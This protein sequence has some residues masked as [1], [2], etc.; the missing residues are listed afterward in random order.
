MRID[1]L[2]EFSPIAICIEEFFEVKR[3]QDHIFLEAYGN[4]AYALVVDAQKASAQDD[5]KA[6]V[7]VKEGDNGSRMMQLFQRF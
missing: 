2:D 1:P 3:P 4:A 5:V 6:P 7:L